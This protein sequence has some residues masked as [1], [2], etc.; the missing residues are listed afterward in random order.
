M[1]KKRI[2]V[3]VMAAIEQRIAAGDYF[4]KSLPGERKLAE[5][6]GVSYMT[7]RKAV[8]GLIDRGILA[9]QPN[10]GLTVGP[11]QASRNAQA[12][13][14]MLT[15]AY[16]SPHLLQCRE[17][18][19]RAAEAQGVRLRSVEY[20][21]WYDPILVEALEN[22]DGMVVIPSTEPIPPRL[23]ETFLPPR[24]KVV[25][26]DDDI[27]EWG[28][29][30]V[31]LF[32]RR[33]IRRVFEHL[34]RLGHRTIDCVN[35][36]G[37]SREIERRIGEWRIWLADREAAGSLHDRP[38]EAYRDPTAAACRAVGRL[39]QKSGVGRP[40]ALV[41]TTYP[42]AIGAVRACHDSGLAIGE[43]ISIAAMN[44]EPTGRYLCPS[45]T[46]LDAPDIAPLLTRCF[47]W[48]KSD[49]R[50]WGGELLISPS[51]SK[52]FVGE[53]TGPAPRA[54]SLCGPP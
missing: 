41:C 54:A 1:P 50:G 21:H 10:G 27:S 37:H 53:S 23:L 46:G 44:C 43:D 40:T 49:Q 47:D 24:N 8:L 35:T 6:L 2:F 25:F 48:F 38:V 5:E 42:A 30:S 13:V 36:Q 32:S 18:V 19:S 39:L 15:P 11:E 26:L 14:A 3:D 34:W 51:E 45:L 29:P 17:A 52:L 20:V 28:I 22:A 31:R 7:A 12:K 16:P 33:N 4:F 9:R